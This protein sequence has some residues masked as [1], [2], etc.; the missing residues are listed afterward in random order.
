MQLIRLAI[1]IILV[2]SFNFS[3]LPQSFANNLQNKTDI[4]ADLDTINIKKITVVYLGQSE[5]SKALFYAKTLEAQ[6]VLEQCGVKINKINT[7]SL[8]FFPDKVNYLAKNSMI[9]FFHSINSH[10]NFDRTITLYVL[11]QFLEK[12]YSTGKSYAEWVDLEPEPINSILKNTLWFATATLFQ[13]QNEKSRYSIIAHEFV[14]LLTK[15][16]SHYAPNPPNQL[17][18]ISY[19]TNDILPATCIEMRKNIIEQNF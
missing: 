18:S 7:V 8:D 13:N 6:K 14:H 12:E 15:R 17:S 9:K 2:I 1:K 4:E 19:R 5:E 3:N 16:G 11:T 10:F